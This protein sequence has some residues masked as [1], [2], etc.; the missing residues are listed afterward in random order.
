MRLGW[1]AVSSALLTMVFGGGWIAAQSERRWVA[2]DGREWA[3]F[4][5]R[6]KHAYVAGFLAGAAL[7]DGERAAQADTAGLHAI[8]DSL[9]RV[10]GLR[11]PYGQGVYATQLDEFY[12]WDNHVPVQLYL[13]LRG[14]NHRMRTGQQEQQ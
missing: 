11:F 4:A 2:F 10:G 7:A 13:A 1:W 8:V 5:P 9:Y 6:E 14:I 3:G 12:W